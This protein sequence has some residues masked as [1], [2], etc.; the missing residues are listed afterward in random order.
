MKKL[1]NLTFGAFLMLFML[2]IS[3]C[4]ESTPVDK[5][6]DLIN[7][8][9]SKVK[10]VK[11]IQEIANLDEVFE[12]LGKGQEQY[13][14]DNADYELTD[15]DRN[16]IKKAINGLFEAVIDK[17]VDLSGGMVTKSQME[18]AIGQ[19]TKLFEAQI[20]KCQK[21]GDLENLDFNM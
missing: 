16:K 11:N 19:Y 1:F 5:F 17:T 9:T 8:A 21:L 18:G 2:Q 20:D 4:G 3:S 12:N 14:Q 7:E 13:F 15:A 6:V 10:S